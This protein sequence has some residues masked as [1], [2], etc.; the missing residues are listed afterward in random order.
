MRV[1]MIPNNLGC[2]VSPMMMYNDCIMYY[3]IVVRGYLF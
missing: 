1:L 3:D 2:R